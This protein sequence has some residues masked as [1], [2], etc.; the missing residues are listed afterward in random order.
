MARWRGHIA[1]HDISEADSA[2]LVRTNAQ[3]NGL[4]NASA[5]DPWHW[6]L[7]IL[8]RAAFLRDTDGSTRG[9]FDSLHRAVGAI[10]DKAT[11]PR[12]LGPDQR[13]RLHDAVCQLLEALP[14]TSGDLR[15]CHLGARDCL[16]DAAKHAVGSA[17]PTANAASLLKET[18][19]W[20]RS[21]AQD[22][23]GLPPSIGENDPRRQGRKHRRVLVIARPEDLGVWLAETQL[24][25]RPEVRAED[26][27]LA[28]VAVSRARL[29]LILASPAPHAQVDTLRSLGFA[30]PDADA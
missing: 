3:A 18:P 26:T 15:Q 2:A 4:N 25:N 11:R 30:T 28:D 16:G 10:A 29:I 1:Q 24:A 13:E 5:A 22:A 23:F 7:G 20:D 8:G 27:R 19:P 12:G 14:R 17:R 21:E 9:A 6:L